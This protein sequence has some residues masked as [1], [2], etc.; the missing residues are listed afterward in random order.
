MSAFLI[1]WDSTTHWRVIPFPLPD[2]ARSWPGHRIDAMPD[3][4]IYETINWCVA[5]MPKLYEDAGSPPAQLGSI[6]R[7]PRRDTALSARVWLRDQPA[8]RALVHETVQRQLAFS[9][10]TYEYLRRFVLQEQRQGS[11][12]HSAPPPWRDPARLRDQANFRKLVAKE[13]LEPT[14]EE[15]NNSSQ[16]YIDI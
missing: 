8:F 3:G 16:R 9:Q 14:A 12:V 4:A 11:Q 7:I 10:T 1:N 6:V 5:N 15:A 2:A 13:T